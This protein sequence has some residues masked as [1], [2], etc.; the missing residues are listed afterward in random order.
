MGQLEAAESS[1]FFAFC[2][3]VP[4]LPLKT[5]K[6]KKRGENTTA[7]LLCAEIRAFTKIGFWMG[8]WDRGD[9][10]RRQKTTPRPRPHEKA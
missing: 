8:Q 2:P 7:A 4:E 10:P 6:Q 5:K 1:G 9:V 3:I